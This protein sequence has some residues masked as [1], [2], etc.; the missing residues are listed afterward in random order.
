MHNVSSQLSRVAVFCS[1]FLH[2]SQTFIYNELLSH[3][4]YEAD[5]F[6]W[7]RLHRNRFPYPR[8]Y[9][10]NLMYAL[11]RHS[12]YFDKAFQTKHYSLVHAHFGTSGIYAHAYAKRFHIPL[13]VTF[14]GYDVAV[15]RNPWRFPPQYWPCMWWGP[16]MLQD[17]TLGLCASNDLRDMLI[18]LGVSADKLIVYKLG[19][20]V[21]SFTKAERDP[22]MV[23]IAMVGRFVEKK[24]F[25]YGIRAFAETSKDYNNI[26]LKIIG[27][28]KLE[29]QLRNLVNTLGVASK[30]TFTGVL[31]PLEVRN[32]LSRTDILIA[33]SIVARNGDR[34]SGLIVVKEASASHVVPIGTYHGGIPDII[35]DGV[36][37]Y[38]V[39]ERDW[40]AIA[41][42]L[43]TLVK[44]P[45]ARQHMAEAGRVKMEKEYNNVD[46]L[47]V[48]EA[49]YD[50]AIATWTKIV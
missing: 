7:R 32:I 37:G 36:T 11:T 19:I 27:A 3:T 25:E 33:P 48:L 38:L 30:V 1:N 35:E 14:H 20:E 47:E 28:G 8:V 17:M 31:S 2:Y 46:R 15:L 6:A 45:I 9:T 4:R 24:G 18:G 21:F 5:V 13:V 39:P 23:N 50:T 43:H 26:C 40:Q 22:N 42:R 29:K 34:D 44:D 16:A 41:H 10:G 12:T 49:L